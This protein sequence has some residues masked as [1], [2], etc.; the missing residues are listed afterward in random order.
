MRNHSHCKRKRLAREGGC[1]AAKP[2]QK[3]RG[4][5][6]SA[7]NPASSSMPSDWYPEKS[8][9]T[10]TK[11]KKHAKQNAKLTRGHTL[12]KASNEAARPTHMIALSAVSLD[13]I[14]NND[15]ASQ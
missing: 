13:E 1:G 5:K 15:G 11:D 9:A 4:A 3:P 12:Q 8:P 10:E 6:K 14:Q 7:R 2:G